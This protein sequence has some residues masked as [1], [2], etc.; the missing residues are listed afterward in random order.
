MAFSPPFCFT[1]FCKFS[2]LI[3]N[4][5][6]GKRRSCTVPP[7]GKYRQR[8]KL[9][10]PATN[11]ESVQV[12]AATLSARHHLQVT[13]R[14]CHLQYTLALLLYTHTKRRYGSC[15]LAML[16]AAF[17]MTFGARFL[18]LYAEGLSPELHAFAP[19]SHQFRN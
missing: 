5:L 13:Y 3:I 11:A 10:H 2:Q 17:G 7:S 15:F 19:S 6:I 8:N 9:I 14:I 4:I 18:Q 12:S 1:N 16:T